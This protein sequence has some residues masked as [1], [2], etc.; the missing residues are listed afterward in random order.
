MSNN[1]N[2][3]VVPPPPPPANSAPP[4]IILP[5]V[6]A[7]TVGTSTPGQSAYQAGV[8]SS[9]RQNNMINSLSGGKKRYLK[10]GS[11]NNYYVPQFNMLYNSQNGPGQN[12]NDVIK[13]SVGTAGQTY[14]N[15]VYD[16][17]VGKTNCAGQSGGTRVC[18]SGQVNCW[19]CYSGGKKKGRTSK[20][21]R[22]CKKGKISNKRRTCKKG[23]ICK[24]CKVYKK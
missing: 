2:S 19:G 23:R 14:A 12:P 3:Q 6:Q 10:G 1:S 7:L 20:K 11:Y 15:Q 24:K 21:G 16:G 4:G 8:N 17:C 18:N 22:T 5:T 9:V 13:H